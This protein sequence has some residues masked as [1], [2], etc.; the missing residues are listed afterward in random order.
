MVYDK[1]AK[2]PEAL[3]MYRKALVIDEIS[4][5]YWNI[6]LVCE[7][8]AEYEEALEY[9][10]KD[11]KIATRV[12]GLEH[13]EAAKTKGNIGG[14]LRVRVRAVYRLREGPG[15]DWQTRSVLGCVY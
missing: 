15:P 5:A 13:L 10:T 8:M 1:Q 7:K 9:H 14:V 2:Y 6:G 4:T 3:D 11:L 12:Y